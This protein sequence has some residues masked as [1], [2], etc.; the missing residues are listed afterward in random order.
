MANK[1]ISEAD[2]KLIDFQYMQNC[3]DDDHPICLTNIK[4]QVN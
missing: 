4:I 1:K 3:I 2:T